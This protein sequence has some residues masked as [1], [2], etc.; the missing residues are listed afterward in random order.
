MK[1]GPC[2]KPLSLRQLVVCS[3]QSPISFPKAAKWWWWWLGTF[4]AMAFFH[5]FWWL[6]WWSQGQNRKLMN[7]VEVVRFDN[8]FDYLLKLASKFK[9]LNDLSGGVSYTEFS[10]NLRFGGHLSIQYIKSDIRGHSTTT[11]TKFYTIL[12]GQLWTFYM[13]PSLCQKRYQV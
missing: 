13:I 10:D 11:R 5:L 12:S 3:L 2:E 4:F 1:P 6:L 7:Q 8:F 9:E